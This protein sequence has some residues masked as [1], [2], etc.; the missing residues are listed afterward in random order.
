GMNPFACL[1]VGVAMGMG[2]GLLNGLL[3]TKLK[4]QPFIA[5]MGAMSIYRGAAYLYTQGIP[6][7]GVPS[8]Y[9]F[10]VDGEICP[11]IRSSII[12]FIIFAIIVHVLLKYTCFGNH[13]YAV[14]GN[15]EAA[16]LSGV[17]V[18]KVKAMIYAVGMAGTALAAIVQLGKLGA[19]DPTTGQGYEL[20]AI[21]AAAIGGTSMAGGRG[22]VLGTVLGAILFSGLKVGLI[23][24]GVDIFWQY[25]ATGLVIIV[26]AYVEVL[27]NR[28]SSAPSGARA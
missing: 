14:G 10:F 26:S 13:V 8:N 24:A 11:Y 4:L 23:V 17:R 25:V 12:I 28:I 22:T 18:N 15:E 6:V 5:T 9:R 2:L 19:G 3:V 7:I 1:V 20:N 16:R 27:Q 21:A